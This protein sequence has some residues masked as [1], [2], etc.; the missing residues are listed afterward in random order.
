MHEQLVAIA[1]PPYMR[2][3]QEMVDSTQL[4]TLADM[5]AGMRPL[6]DPALFGGTISKKLLDD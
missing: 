4:K 1:D 6:V 3:M 2:Q 5:F